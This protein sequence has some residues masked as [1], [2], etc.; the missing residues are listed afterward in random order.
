MIKGTLAQRADELLGDRIAFVGATV[1]RAQR[2]TSARVGDTALVLADGTIEGFV[3]GTCAQASVRVHAKRALETGEPLILRLVPGSAQAGEPPEAPD[4][5]VVA[6]N[7]CLSGGSVDILLE[8]QLPA[9]R[10]I[11]VGDAPI[12][13]ALEELARAAGYDVFRGDSFEVDPQPGDA[14][15][16]VASHGADEEPVLVKALTAGIGYVALVCSDVRGA[17]VRESL[18]LPEELRRR[19]HAPAGLALGATSPA[20]IAIAILAEFVAEGKARPVGPEITAPEDATGAPATAVDPICGMEVVAA[21]TT[22][23]LD[24]NGE[25]MY[26][27]REKCRTTYAEEHAIDVPGQ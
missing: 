9:P 7:P 26:F 3:G 19:L 17:A 4:G 8:P 5:T 21:E 10:V 25:R 22:L 27:C 6:H 11:V 12:A 23:H 13:R 1:V 15:V 2:P 18:E 16:I 20:E 24:V 14:A